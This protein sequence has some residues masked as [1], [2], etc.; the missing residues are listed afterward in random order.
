MLDFFLN[1]FLL[2]STPPGA[3]PARGSGC[4]EN[5]R[6][7]PPPLPPAQSPSGRCRRRRGGFGL[8]QPSHDGGWSRRTTMG[9]PRAGDRSHPG[10]VWSRSG[11]PASLGWRIGE[12]GPDGDAEATGAWW[13]VDA[14]GIDDASSRHR[15]RSLGV[16]PEELLAQ[17]PAVPGSRMR[18]NDA[19][20]TLARWREQTC[21]AQSGS[22]WARSGF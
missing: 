20:T 21:R 6:K 18:A 19:P 7:P 9:L 4:P 13:C 14:G 17:Q 12:D 10:G 16:R 11:S 22:Y 2:Q 5:P 1:F 3:S 15:Q 8:A